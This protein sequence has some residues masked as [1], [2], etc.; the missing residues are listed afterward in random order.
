MLIINTNRFFFMSNVYPV[1]IVICADDCCQN[2]A[3]TY[4]GK[5]FSTENS[6]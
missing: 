1:F 5:V 6:I 4:L 2:C 3:N